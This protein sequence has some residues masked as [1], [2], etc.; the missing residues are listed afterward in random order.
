[1]NQSP[2][3]D[4]AARILV[5]LGFLAVVV[6]GV[7][8]AALARANDSATPQPAKPAAEDTTK[9]YTF[10]W[11]ITSDPA[12]APRGGTTKGPELTLDKSV[13]RSLEDAAGTR[14]VGFRT[15]SPRHSRDGGHVPRELRLPGSHA[16]RPRCQTRAS[17]PILGHG[18]RLCR[19]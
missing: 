9:R 11:P 14:P 16:L 13:F 8:V 10:S 5:R 1:M 6:V 3:L 2:W 7:L 15:R 19:P 17:V 4:R 18:A 12:L